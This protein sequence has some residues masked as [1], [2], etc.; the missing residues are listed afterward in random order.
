MRNKTLVITRYE[1][2][3]AAMIFQNQSLEWLFVSNKE[4]SY[5]GRIYVGRIQKID[6]V[7]QAAFVE[8]DKGKL[9]YLSLKDIISDD[10]IVVGAQLLVQLKKEAIKTK[11][12][13]LTCDINLSKKYSVITLKE[14]GI[15]ISKKI[16][17]IDKTQFLTNLNN[18]G[19]VE[20]MEQSSYGFILR[21]NAVYEATLELLKEEVIQSIKEL[22]L[23]QQTWKNRTFFS[24]LYQP[25]QLYL[26]TIRDLSTKKYDSI[27]TDQKDIFE[28]LHATNQFLEKEI[29]LYDDEKISLSNLYSINTKILECL[30]KKVWLKN[31]G[32]FIVES[33]EA[34]HVIDV[35]SGKFTKKKWSD[36]QIL[37]FNKEAAIDIVRHIRL[38][39]L[40]GIIIIDFINH[41]K[42]EQDKELLSYL[43]TLTKNEEI[44]TFV[45]DMTPLGLVEITREKIKKSLS[46]EMKK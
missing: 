34:L 36:E 6:Q 16:S 7:L 29:R 43:T 24:C 11:L 41:N 3:I 31:G 30:D 28:E 8:Y 4:P 19:L 44:K 21:T 46:E 17:K 23:I 27:L 32:Y 15:G 2:K 10:A 20:K 14:P 40:S 35:N 22:D 13:T 33:T 18:Y 5:L 12:P 1:E 26:T 25:E 38:R 9:G 42:K 39:N 37:L 45:V